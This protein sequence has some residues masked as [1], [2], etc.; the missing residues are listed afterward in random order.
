MA[1]VPWFSSCACKI[2]TNNGIPKI[3]TF[4]Q[5]VLRQLPVVDHHSD[6]GNGQRDEVHQRRRLSVTL[7]HHR[8]IIEEEVRQHRSDHVRRQ[9][10]HVEHHRVVLLHE[11]LPLTPIMLHYR[12]DHVHREETNDVPREESDRHAVPWNGGQG[13]AL[14]EDDEQKGEDG[15]AQSD[16]SEEF[17]LRR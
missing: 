17:F 7:A 8:Y 16:H 4:R 1:G 10:V 13:A 15:A 11:H 6:D 2:A 3:P 14:E 5:V 12:G 9:Q